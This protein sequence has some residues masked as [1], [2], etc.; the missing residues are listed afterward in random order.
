MSLKNAHNVGEMLIT[1]LVIG[2]IAALTLPPVLKRDNEKKIVESLNH[3]HTLFEEAFHKAQEKNGPVVTWVPLTSFSNLV[4]GAKESEPSDIIFDIL[5]K[6]LVMIEVCEKNTKGCFPK[7]TYKKPNGHPLASYFKLN[8]KRGRTLS[9]ASFYVDVT[10]PVCA[11][12]ISKKD[13]RPLNKV[14]G[15]IYV[16]ING[17]RFPN[18]AGLDLFVFHITQYGIVPAGM[19]DEVADSGSSIETCST[20][21]LEKGGDEGWG[22]CA[23][24]KFKENLLYL[25]NDVSW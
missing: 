18:Q 24:L 3:T 17:D 21:V 23:W 10:S 1:I 5:S 19:P 25:K 16:D 7:D 12:N 11:Q 6:E 2:V 8:K 22:C 20:K 15:K 4:N 13:A 14:C 9:G